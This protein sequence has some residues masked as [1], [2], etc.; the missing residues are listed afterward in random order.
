M[1]NKVKIGLSLLIA[2]AFIIPTGAVMAGEPRVI[3]PG[4]DKTAAEN[5]PDLTPEAQKDMYGDTEIA[6]A[7]VIGENEVPVIPQA[8]T[9]TIGSFILRNPADRWIYVFDGEAEPVEEWYQPM[10]K[11]IT[12]AAPSTFEPELELYRLSCD[13]QHLIYHTSFEDNAANYLEWGEVDG[14]CGLAGGYYDGWSWSDA[15]ACD[16]DHSFKCTMYDEY[17]NM[18]EDYLYMKKTFDLTDEIEALDGTCLDDIGEVNVTFD[19]YVAGEYDTWYVDFWYNEFYTP[20]DYLMFG[21]EQFGSFW[22]FDNGDG[23]AFVDSAGY[24][25]PGNYYFM[26]TSLPLFDVDT[27]GGPY[28]DYTCKASKIDGCPGWWHVWA[29]IPVSILPDKEN[30]GIWFGWVSDKERTFEGAYV[31]NVN[32]YAKQRLG[33]KIYQGHSQDWITEEEDGV[34][35]FTFP[36]KWTDVEPGVYRAICKIKTDDGSYVDHDPA[37]P[38]IQHYVVEFKIQDNIDCAITNISVEDSF[39]GQEVADGGM[40]TYTADAHIMFDYHNAGNIAVEDVPVKATAY[41]LVKDQ[42]F[43]DDMEGP[44]NWQGFS[45]EYPAPYNIYYHPPYISDKFSWSGSKSLA[46][47]EPET[48]H[49]IPHAR[50]IAYSQNGFSMEDVKEA[51]LDLYYKAV[52]PDGARIY[53]CALGHRYIVGISGALPSGPLVQKTWIG[54]MQPQGNYLQID[55]MRIWDIMV[56]NGYMTDENG[57][58]TY[59]TGIGFWLDT[60]RVADGDLFPYY[61]FEPGETTWS[62]LYIDD[63]SITATVVG[64]KVWEDAMTIP[65]P[66]EPCETY[67]GQFEWEDV[68]YS[69]YQVVVE[70]LCDNDVYDGNNMKS[71]SFIVLDDLEKASKVNFVDYTECT[72]DNWCISDVVG[73]DCGMDHY[74]LATN[75]DTHYYPAGV[76][77]YVAL[78]YKDSECCPGGIDISHINYGSGGGGGNILYS[79]DFTSGVFPAGW[80]HTDPQPHISYSDE[81]GGVAPE[82]DFYWSTLYDGDYFETDALPTGDTL[83]F[84]SYIDDYYGAAYPYSCKVYVNGNDVTPWSNPITGDVGPTT[85]SI[86]ISAYPNPV[87]RFEFTGDPWGI[88]DWYI[89]DIKIIGSAGGCSDVFTT[90]FEGTPW[91]GDFASNTGWLQGSSYYGSAHSGSEWAYAWDAGV[92]LTTPTIT[93]GTGSTTLTFWYAAESSSHPMDLE[94]WI[95][96]YPGG[97]MVWHDYGYTHTTYQEATVDL[98]SYTGDH[99]I[100]FVAQT[101][102]FYGQM[103]DDI[104]IETCAGAGIPADNMYFNMTYQVDMYAGDVIL[105]VAS[106][107]STKTDL[108]FEA[109][110]DYGDGWYVN[111]PCGASGYATVTVYLNDEIVYSGYP[112]SYVSVDFQAGPN[113]QVKIDYHSPE[114]D[115]CGAGACCTWEEEHSW[116]LSRVCDGSVIAEDG[117]PDT[118]FQD[119][120]EDRV[121]GPWHIDQCASTGCHVIDERDWVTID[122]YS[123]NTPGVCQFVSY[124]LV[125]YFTPGSD[126]F[127]L[128]LLLDTSMLPDF[129]TGGWPGIGFHV[130][131]FSI[132]NMVDTSLP[133][134]SCLD[135]GTVLFNFEDGTMDGCFGEEV[136]GPYMNPECQACTDCPFTL[137]EDCVLGGIHWEQTGD[138]C[139]KAEFPAAPVDEAM[140][141]STE[142]E[143]AYEAYLS[144]EWEYDLHSGQVL[145][146]ELSADGGNNWYTMARVDEAGSYS[147]PIIFG[148]T[149][150]GDITSFDL[151]PWAG[152]SLLIRVRIQNIGVDWD[153]DGISD[154]WYDG[155]VEVCNLEIWGKQD[156]TPPTAA[157]TLSGNMVAPGLYAGPVTVTITG[158][159]DHGVK[160]IHYILDGTENIAP[161]DRAVFTV[162]DDG[163]H[164]VEYWAVDTTGNEG[165]H[166]SV[167]FSI[168]ATPPTVAITAP[169]P[170]FYLFGNKLFDMSKPFIIGA[171][172]IQA[173]ADDAQGVAV[174]K[175]YL[176]GELIGE[177]TET[178]YSVYCAVKHMGA[179]T[180]KVVAFDGVGNNAED[181]LDITY[182]KFL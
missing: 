133:E 69:H 36:L 76:K 46:F 45:G 11:L 44:S 136:T 159:D 90:G 180:I 33:E 129:T 39:T 35:Y 37:T 114:A 52:L 94:V 48:S 1:R 71:S 83:E 75:C 6:I 109:W 15:R 172:N 58:I 108:K 154:Y 160:E 117:T 137:C 30:F 49:I 132:T 157:I 64:D 14:D 174:V 128:R 24:S 99:T 85:Y 55:W 105:Q 164:T 165:Q 89:D 175:F 147:G 120:P 153:D 79:E 107:N 101:S 56:S 23:Q 168:D 138:H 146:L 81:A 162:S 102:D 127:A 125:P 13:D 171:F 123:G 77:D 20:L 149:L 119:C 40:F 43:F 86:D 131:H 142:I 106:W 167:T 111:C 178:P 67:R 38:G 22:Y 78:T 166:G 26:D 97:T 32:I 28:K 135:S 118:P 2:L 140:V 65:G 74:A 130:H 98:S 66:C 17:K 121:W 104:N 29:N 12:A 139:W 10:F 156:S 60:T 51:Y 141:W 84:K 50:Y 163:S 151:T 143:D 5:P 116:R 169:E 62:G 179:G 93:F 19:I 21:I 110:D 18:Q 122:S 176:D 161:G 182:Y 68:P 61:A 87:I 72:D 25:L 53:L 124:D 7:G 54:P 57:H 59:D 144:G 91:D 152:N 126:R 27:P 41:K 173:T 100:S 42:L 134:Y 181:T 103:L 31:D 95:D 9:T 96:G 3:P 8:T 158:S 177:S 150:Y 145:T 16:G 92:A 113:D 82:V 47:N 70:T 63:V 155:N 112:T 4:G 170:G 88:M 73:N 148:S 115:I 80:T 34:S